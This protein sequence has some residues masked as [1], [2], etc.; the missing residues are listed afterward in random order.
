MSIQ[1]EAVVISGYKIPR[2]LWQK[3]WEFCEEH[4]Q[5]DQFNIPSD[6]EDLFIDMDPISGTGETF[7]AATIYT[8]DEC[9][10]PKEFDTI[11]ADAKTILHVQRSFDIVFHN[12]YMESGFPTPSFNKYLGLRWI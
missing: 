10:A 3:G 2:E 4:W 9:S 11:L 5:D 6:W 7:F 8:V 1:A 12:I